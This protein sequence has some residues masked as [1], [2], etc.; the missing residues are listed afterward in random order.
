MD[1]KLKPGE[2]KTEQSS[3]VWCTVLIWNSFLSKYA[4]YVDSVWDRLEMQECFVTS[5]LHTA[6]KVQG[7]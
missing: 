4:Q 5:S 7:K 2:T 6:F 1:R 3:S